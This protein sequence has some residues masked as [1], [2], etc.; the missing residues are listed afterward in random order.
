VAAVFDPAK[1]V[2]GPKPYGGV[3]R[4][5]RCEN[6]VAEFWTWPD[7]RVYI[8]RLFQVYEKGSE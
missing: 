6:Q 7:G 5:V 1:I 8:A 4:V 2:V 3:R